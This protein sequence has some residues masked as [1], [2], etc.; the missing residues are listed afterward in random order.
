M[1]LRFGVLSTAKIAV[2]KVVPAMKAAAACEVTAIASRDRARARTAAE[3]LGIAHAYGHYEELLV[4]DTVD[5]VYIPLPNHLHAQWTAAAAAAG[6]HVLCEKPLAMTAVEARDM[7]AGCRAAGVQLMEAFMYRFHPQWLRI[8]ELVAAGRFGELQGLQ[9]V[10]AYDN[11]DPADIRNIAAIRGGG[12]FGIGCFA[13]DSARLGLASVAEQVVAAARIDPDFGTDVL[14]TAVLAFPGGRHAAFTCGTQTA[15]AQWVRL[16]GSEGG[17]LVETPFDVNPERPTRLVLLGPGRDDAPEN[18][19]V[20]AAN[21]FTLQ[22]E[23]FA[24]AVLAGQP[25]PRPPEESVATMEALDA[26]RRAWA[27]PAPPA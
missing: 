13:V 10:F 25:V 11:R 7:A 4:S 18:V 6:K 17:A 19:E 3:R 21:H 5:A 27:A 8:H 15:R 2:T 12:V 14:T 9:T 24:Q 20:P 16:V 22:A 1:P 23:A 26:V